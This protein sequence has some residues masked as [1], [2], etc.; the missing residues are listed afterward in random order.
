MIFIA[1][2]LSLSQT[3]YSVFDVA[4]EDDVK[5]LEVSSIKNK[6]GERPEK[7]HNIGNVLSELKIKYSPDEVVFERGFTRYHTSTQALY[8]VLGVSMYIFHDTKQFLYAP[9]TVKK[10]LTGSG[11]AKKEDV[12]GEVEKLYPNIDF[13]N[14][15]ES[16]SVAVGITHLRKKYG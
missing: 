6:K 11:K 4:S 3:G 15:D 1:F 16:D 7:L 9:T 2:D 14:T 8:Q 13:C 10:S 5:I 12:L